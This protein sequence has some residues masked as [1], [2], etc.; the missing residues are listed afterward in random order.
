MEECK[1]FEPP[2][3]SPGLTRV[4]L[5]L[6]WAITMH[7]SQ[8]RTVDKA[9][10]DLGKFEATAGLAP[11]RLSRAK[12]L[13]DFLMERMP[14]DRSS[15]LGEKPTIKLRVEEEIRI[16]TVSIET[17]PRHGVRVP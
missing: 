14:F 5:A 7:K 2:N 17:L 1:G 9:V 13:V 6:C 3:V 12:R 10:I 4:P 8:G 11:V 15:K 16:K